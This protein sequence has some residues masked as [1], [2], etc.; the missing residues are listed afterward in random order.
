[1]NLE[2]PDGCHHLEEL[3][4]STVANG[5]ARTMT[6]FSEKILLAL[7]FMLVEC[8]PINGAVGKEL[9]RGYRQIFS[10]SDWK[11]FSEK[12]KRLIGTSPGKQFYA[13]SAS[14]QGFCPYPHPRVWLPCLEQACNC[15]WSENS[16][17]PGRN[18][19][20]EQEG[21]TGG[22]FWT[23]SSPEAGQTGIPGTG[24]VS[25]IISWPD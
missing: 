22:P 9:T 25:G 6:M 8:F 14:H 18:Y 2:S 10:F 5:S 23:K 4:S 24:A 1:V 12:P 13:A 20:D 3:N 21:S 19:P 7:V 15:D 16:G 17:L 11:Y